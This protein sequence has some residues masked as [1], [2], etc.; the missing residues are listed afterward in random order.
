MQI[1]LINT[2][3][4]RHIFVKCVVFNIIATEEHMLWE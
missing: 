1:K 3:S 2:E 4:L